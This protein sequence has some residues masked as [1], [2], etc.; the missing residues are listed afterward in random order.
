[1][2]SIMP[3]MIMCGRVGLLTSRATFQLL[4]KPEGKVGFFQTLTQYFSILPVNSEV[5]LLKETDLNSLPPA[6]CFSP[7]TP[8]ETIDFCEPDNNDCFAEID[9]LILVTPDVQTWF[10]TQGNQWQALLTII[11]GIEGI[12][13]AF[14]NSGI[15]NKRIRWRAE[16]FVFDTP[17]ND[18]FG[19]D[20]P[21]DIEDDLL[22]DLPALASGLREQQQADI[23]MM[24][25]SSKTKKTNFAV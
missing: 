19:F 9:L 17:A 15:A 4:K 12:N 7:S 23:V 21:M 3:P 5:S 6:D 1:M 24:L 10:G 2:L 8:E 18:G 20:T 13:L 16:T 25:T 11:Q 22:I 14:A